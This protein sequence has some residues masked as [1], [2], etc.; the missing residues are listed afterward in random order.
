MIHRLKLNINYSKRYDVHQL[1]TASHGAYQTTKTN[2]TFPFPSG[3]NCGAIFN[4]EAAEISKT[5]SFNYPKQHFDDVESRLR[6]IDCEG[7][8]D[9]FLHDRKPSVSE[10]VWESLML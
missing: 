2:F 7:I 5:L 3:I 9:I 8:A 4:G 1:F 10:Q 6:A